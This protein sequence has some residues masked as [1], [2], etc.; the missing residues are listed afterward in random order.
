MSAAEERTPVYCNKTVVLHLEIVYLCLLSMNQ[1]KSSSIHP[2]FSRCYVEGLIHLLN[3][4]LFKM[5][6]RVRVNTQT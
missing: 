5:F 3:L 1:E 6:V 4:Q 2:R